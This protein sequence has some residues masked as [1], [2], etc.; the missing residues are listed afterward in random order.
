MPPKLKRSEIVRPVLLII[1]LVS[2]IV[3]LVAIQVASHN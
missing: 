1:A 3:L 2:M